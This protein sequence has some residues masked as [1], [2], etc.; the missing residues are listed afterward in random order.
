MT[1]K[2]KGV[3]SGYARH[4]KREFLYSTVLRNWQDAV[5]KGDPDLI[6]KYDA[7]HKRQFVEC[8]N[9]H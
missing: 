5:K 6:E 7:Q 4:G 8:N 1:K 9:Y 3:I 2:A